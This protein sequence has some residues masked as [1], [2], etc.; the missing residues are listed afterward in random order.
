MNTIYILMFIYN[1]YINKY[2]VNIKI[3]IIN[4]E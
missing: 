4:M 2:K 1:N 3:Q